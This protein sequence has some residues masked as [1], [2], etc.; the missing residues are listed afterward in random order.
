MD[1]LSIVVAAMTLTKLCGQVITSLYTCVGDIGSIDHR[2]QGFCDEIKSLGGTVEMLQAALKESLMGDVVRAVDNN[3]GG[4]LWSQVEISIAD[5]T[6]T[7]ETLE[8]IFK[9]L[10]ATGGRGFRP[11]FTQFKASLES[12]EIAVLR[13][14][15]GLFAITLGLPLQ[16]I[17]LYVF[18][19]N[20][21]TIGLVLAN[22]SL[23]SCLQV[24]QKD[25]NAHHKEQVNQK[26]DTL[27]KAVDELQSSLNSGRE[28]HQWNDGVVD[29]KIYK[30][31]VSCIDVVKTF[32]SN[33]S[34]TGGIAS[35]K[36]D[37][38]QETKQKHH[39][40]VLS[41]ENPNPWAS[42]SLT[43]S[44]SLDG[45]AAMEK[46]HITNDETTSIT[47]RSVTE[48]PPIDSI[49]S[50]VREWVP[51]PHRQHPLPSTP[52][53]S[54]PVTYTNQTADTATDETIPTTPFALDEF[55][56][57]DD[58]DFEVD[59]TEELLER[60]RICFETGNYPKAEKVLTKVSQR[61]LKLSIPNTALGQEDINFMLAISS[62]KTGKLPEAESILRQMTSH[63]VDHDS[64]Q[65]LSAMHTL[66]EVLLAAQK[67][68][69]A[70]IFCKKAL[71]RRRKDKGKQHTSYH[72]SARLLILIKQKQG[73]V[74]VVEALKAHLKKVAPPGT[75]RQGPSESQLNDTET[76]SST[77]RSGDEW[78][79][80]STPLRTFYQVAGGIK[81]LSEQGQ[82]KEAAELAMQL[83]LEYSNGSR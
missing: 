34:S 74:E 9:R 33:A 69:E 58:S 39:S 54:L 50:R 2:I 71:E 32:A 10:K 40:I 16:M 30:N 28:L 18:S 57:Q 3:T 67:V 27:T 55:A 61:L 31:I 81:R 14:R 15:I 38:K 23:L 82:S 80:R 12:G 24:D 52:P 20:E 19:D 41:E 70:E 73:D 65:N 76:T 60:G 48:A 1:P 72:E 83:L 63:A 17:S 53:S 59:I 77:Q 4:R 79:K 5:C 51:L 11:A 64:A 25:S 13:G 49:L 6:S 35:E 44:L 68:D 36:N 75:D 47:Q 22:R 7:L 46:H 56:N 37:L 43:P 42:D 21:A 26:L 62:F 66:A 29:V 8:S 78:L 45:G